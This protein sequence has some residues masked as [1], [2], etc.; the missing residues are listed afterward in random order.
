MH[1]DIDYDI[2]TESYFNQFF[3]ITVGTR[4]AAMMFERE[5]AQ[6][7]AVELESDPRDLHPL[8]FTDRIDA[9]M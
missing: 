7:V 1:D 8:L 6:D 4:L 2:D 5:D 3:C 9:T